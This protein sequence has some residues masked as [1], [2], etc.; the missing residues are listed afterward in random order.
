MKEWSQNYLSKGNLP[1][2]DEE[3][4][5]WFRRFTTSL[6]IGN[7][8]A[9]LA[10][11]SYASSAGDGFDSALSFSFGVF[12]LGILLSG[13]LPLALS[14][15]HSMKVPRKR[16]KIR[17]SEEERPEGVYRH[18]IFWALFYW[19]FMKAHFALAIVAAALFSWGLFLVYEQF[20]KMG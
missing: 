14:I 4:S 13:L 8:A 18:P 5:F 2:D 10:I 1:Q 15:R 19:I 20:S 3:S 12:S 11:G 6:A 17:L 16:F 9:A 7:G